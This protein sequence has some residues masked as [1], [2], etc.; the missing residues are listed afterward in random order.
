[1]DVIVDG[2]GP[3]ETCEMCNGKGEITNKRLFFQILGWMSG[4]A[5]MERV[6][7]SKSR[8]AAR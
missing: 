5:R 3:V 1:M 4:L 6:S 8:A 2:Q 7:M